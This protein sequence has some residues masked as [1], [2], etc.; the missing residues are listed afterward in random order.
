[1]L[2]H[3][4]H[5]A[6]TDQLSIQLFQE[7]LVSLKSNIF[8]VKRDSLSKLDANRDSIHHFQL[9]LNLPYPSHESHPQ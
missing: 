3:V 8:V 4:P 2:F 1:M 7:L 5:L 6:L 9:Q